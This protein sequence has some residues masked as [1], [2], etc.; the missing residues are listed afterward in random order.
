M[1]AS[2]ARTFMAASPPKLAVP[3]P[4]AIDRDLEIK[5]D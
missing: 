4:I 2:A 5:T 3:T 1:Y